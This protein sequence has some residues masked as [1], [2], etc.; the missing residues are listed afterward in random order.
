MRDRATKLN[1][2]HAISNPENDSDND[3]DDDDV[4]GNSSMGD[5]ESDTASL[6]EVEHHWDGNASHSS[7]DIEDGSVNSTSRSEKEGSKEEEKVEEESEGDDEL[8]VHDHC[9]CQPWI[10]AG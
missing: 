10:V 6:A 9:V 3:D 4:P 5:S 7:N 8:E 2:L 1:D